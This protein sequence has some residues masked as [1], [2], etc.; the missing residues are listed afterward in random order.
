MILAKTIQD[1][2]SLADAKKSTGKGE[3]FIDK[4]ASKFQDKDGNVSKRGARGY[5]GVVGGMAGGTIGATAGIV[6]GLTAKRKVQ[7][8]GTKESRGKKVM[9]S[10]LIGL[11]AGTA[12]GGTIGAAAGPKIYKK[13][14]GDLK[15]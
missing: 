1:V 2:F 15:K 4:L 7:A 3:G 8:D 9:K 13:Y 14:V 5:Y 10:T 6:R 12:I 11:G